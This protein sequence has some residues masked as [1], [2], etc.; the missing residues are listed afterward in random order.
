MKLLAVIKRNRD[1][2]I[3]QH[4]VSVVYSYFTH[5]VNVNDIGVNYFTVVELERAKSFRGCFFYSQ[6]RCKVNYETEILITRCSAIAE[7][8][9]CRVHYSFRQK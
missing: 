3:N 4:R 5:Y 1:S 7:R 2:V 8:P 6:R 9:R